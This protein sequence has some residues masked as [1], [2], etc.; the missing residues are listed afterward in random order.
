MV[1]PEKESKGNRGKRFHVKRVLSLLGDPPTAEFYWDFEEIDIS[2]EP[3]SMILARVLIGRVKDLTR[4]RLVLWR[5]PLQQEV[6]AWNWVDWIE[7]AFHG[8]IQDSEALETYIT[9]WAV[10]KETAMR[11]VELK[12]LAR[13]F[14]GTRAYDFTK[15]PTWDM[16]RGAETIP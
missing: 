7:E 15:V 6:K 1:G 4:F 11:Y 14:D 12:R 13:R 9:D 2:M 3:T 5:T 8:A 16:L 10:I